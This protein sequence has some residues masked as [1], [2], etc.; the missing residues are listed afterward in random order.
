MVNNFRLYDKTDRC[1]IVVCNKLP[2]DTHSNRW[3]LVF[4]GNFLPI[5]IRCSFLQWARLSISRF[6]RVAHA[7]PQTGKG[8]LDRTNHTV[9][10]W[11]KEV[12]ILTWI[13]IN[14]HFD[15]WVWR[16]LA[17]ASCAVGCDPYSQQFACKYFLLTWFRFNRSEIPSW[18]FLVLLFCFCCCVTIV[19]VSR[20][21]FV[22]MMVRCIGRCGGSSSGFVGENHNAA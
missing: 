10:L 16:Q 6:D 2:L 19:C 4:D 11:N 15:G 17:S 21:C 18:R 5:R 1:G 3:V 14:F 22:T 20:M 13:E 7:F 9:D 12:G 8:N